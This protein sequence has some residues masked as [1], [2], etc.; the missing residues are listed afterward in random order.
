METS[1]FYRVQNYVILFKGSVKY[2]SSPA[3]GE[4]EE[5]G[6]WER[7]WWLIKVQQDAKNAFI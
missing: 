1:I 2:I 5:E 7:C 6:L 4:R 3:V